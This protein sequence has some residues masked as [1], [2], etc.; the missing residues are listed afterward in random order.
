MNF[1][2]FISYKMRTI[3]IHLEGAPASGFL[4]T[5]MTES[6]RKNIFEIKRSLLTGLL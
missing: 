2:Q 3:H 4:N 6:P 1:G 5:N